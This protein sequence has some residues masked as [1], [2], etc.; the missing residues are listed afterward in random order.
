MTIVLVLLKTLT[1]LVQSQRFRGKI[2]IQKPRAPHFERAT[3]L[4][5]TKPYFEKKASPSLIDLCNKNVNLRKEDV[6]NPFQNIIAK[7]LLQLFRSSRLIGFFHKNS[8]NSEQE[9]K[10]KVLFKRQN[11]DF[12]N[13]GKKT[14]QIAVTGTPYES[15][16]DIYC[17]HN[18]IVFSPQPEIKKMIAVAKKF[19]QLALLGKK[20]S[21]C[22]CDLIF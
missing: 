22:C 17:S 8:M 4:A 19:P 1:P 18:M 7:E 6:E 2:N 15:V 10:A 3:Y 14:L 5:L 13:F 12:K 21:S 9:F 20:Q 11:M 16:L